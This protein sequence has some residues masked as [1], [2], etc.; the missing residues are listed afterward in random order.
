MH[1]RRD[2]GH[3]RGGS[4]H[5]HGRH[6]RRSERGEGRDQQHDECCGPDGG[7]RGDRHGAPGGDRSEQRGGGPDTRFL[8]LE[9]SQV[10]YA[11]AES[12]T[13]QAFRELLVEAAKARWREC[14]GDKIAGLAE[15]AVDEL[16]NDVRSSLEIEAH[17]EAHNR[18]RSHTKERLRDIFGERGAGN[19][20]E[21]PRRDGEGGE[22]GEGEDR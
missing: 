14:F 13:K 16:M 11:E 4:R 15:L 9:M 6:E 1:D 8:Q 2:G 22:G 20:G 17:I 5:E 19:E 7:S 21:S 12:V 10:L 18:D 3:D